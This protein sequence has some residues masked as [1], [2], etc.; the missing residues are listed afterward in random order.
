M[1][2]GSSTLAVRVSTGGALLGSLSLPLVFVASLH[3]WRLAGHQ[4]QNRDATSTIQRRFLSALLSCC[5]S[6]ALVRALATEVEEG[7]LSFAALLGLTAGPGYPCLRCLALTG[8]LFAGPILQHLVAAS[9]GVTRFV[10]WPVGGRWV[11]MRNY[12][13]APFTEEFVFRACLV[14]I[15]VAAGFPA[16]AI[17]FLSP[18]CFALAHAHHFVEHFR[19]CGDKHLA[20][21]Q[22]KFQVFYTSLFGMYSNF[23]LLRTGSTPAL[24][25]AHSFCNHQ[26]FPDL[27]FLVS[28]AHPL[29]RHR[30]WLAGS[31]G[32]GIVG[33]A[34]LLL[35]L[36][37]GFA[38][39]FR[40]G[41][42]AA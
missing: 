26:G 35:P 11:A 29:H 17:I 2:Q 38:S 25:L 28:E 31:Y 36:T 3:L 23:L 4:D 24:V 19:R 27:G 8:V 10:S 39:S 20:L 18:F 42:A 33:F 41:T 9:L 6:A 22:V 34:R 16:G 40:P 13:L 12:V 37:A 1:G 30:A 15:W 21:A 14:R 32:L 5:C 7:G